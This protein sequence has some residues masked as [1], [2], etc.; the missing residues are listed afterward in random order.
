MA[1]GLGFLDVT[2]K[3]R[4]S[5]GGARQPSQYGLTWLPR[6]DGSPASNR[7]ATP[8]PEDIVAV[9]RPPQV[10]PVAVPD[11]GGPTRRRVA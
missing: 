3:G 10:A 9:L 1:V 11:S 2:L 8:A 5:Y 7:W 4:R 6:R